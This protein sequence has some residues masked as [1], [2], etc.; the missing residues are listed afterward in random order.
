MNIKKT[1]IYLLLLC[2]ILTT[3]AN[4]APEKLYQP[5]AN[6]YKEG[7]YHFQSGSGNKLYFKLATPDKPVNLI[8]IEEDN[9][10]YYA[11]LN[12]QVREAQLILAD[13]LKLH[14]AIVVGSG[15]VSFTFE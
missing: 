8:I 14:T 2:T 12:N 3:S 10:K 1:I 4:A 9:I 7:I 6:T 11:Q 13:P 5:I 15:E